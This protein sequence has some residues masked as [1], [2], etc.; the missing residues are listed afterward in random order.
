MTLA[1]LGLRTDQ[2]SYMQYPGIWDRWELYD[3]VKDPDQRK[4]LL[5]ST[6]N[7]MKYGRL[8]RFVTAPLP[9][10]FTIICRSCSR[11]RSIALEEA[12]MQL[13]R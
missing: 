3:V 1:I 10:S 8:D 7:G 11:P 6:L 2:Y 5:G 4:N 9:E 12:S 13:E